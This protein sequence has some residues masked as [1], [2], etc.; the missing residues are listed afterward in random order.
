MEF[1][2]DFVG[3]QNLEMLDLLFGIVLRF[4]LVIVLAV[5]VLLIVREIVMWYWK[6]NAIL[7]ELREVNENLEVIQSFL[8]EQEDEEEDE[9]EEELQEDRVEQIEGMI[10]D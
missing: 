3:I 9:D 10:A 4:L 1:L 6:I 7:F 8:V 5:V 2:Y